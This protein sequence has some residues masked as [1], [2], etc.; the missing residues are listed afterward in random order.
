MTYKK[1]TLRL[2]CCDLAYM[3][4]LESNKLPTIAASLTI[5][6]NEDV[7]VEEIL[8]HLSHKI[9]E[10]IEQNASKKEHRDLQMR[11]SWE[12][13]EAQAR[14]GGRRNGKQLERTHKQNH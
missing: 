7:P 11:Y 9:C 5:G 1:Y 2:D 8:A 14:S 4:G 13:R 12:E 6:K 10:T 3:G